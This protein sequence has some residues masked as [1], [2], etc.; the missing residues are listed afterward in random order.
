MHETGAP[1]SRV[2]R[3]A[4]GERDGDSIAI[5]ASFGCP[6]DIII[7]DVVVILLTEET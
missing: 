4:S 1:V 2:V 3:Q 5:P 6:V 7:L